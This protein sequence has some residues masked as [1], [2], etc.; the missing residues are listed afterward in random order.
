[1][2]QKRTFAFIFLFQVLTFKGYS[3]VD[4]Q[5]LQRNIHI[6]EKDTNK[7]F[8]SFYNLNFLKNNEYF[9][10]I[11][12]GY[13]LFGSN[14]N[15]RFSYV[16]NPYTRIEAGIFL[17]KDFGNPNFTIIAPTLTLKLQKNGYSFLFGNLESS[18]SHQLI[19]P[20]FNYERVINNP[21]ENGLQIKVDKQ[22]IWLDAWI[23]WEQQEY[24][25]SPFQEHIGASLSSLITLFKSDKN[26]K[27]QIP[28][29][30]IIYHNGGQIDADTSA[31]VSLGNVASGIILERSFNKTAF[32]RDIKGDYYWVGYKDLTS[33]NKQLFKMGNGNYIN[34]TIKSKYDVSLMLSY[35][36]SNDFIA[37]HGGFLYQSISSLYGKTDY[38]E[39]VR[40]LIFARL[41]YK[42][43]IFKG[44]FLDVRFEPYYDI[45]HK[46]LEYSYSVYTSFT[47]D[48]LV[49]NFK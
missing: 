13:T 40:K 29:Q 44:L 42:L 10:K 14:T 26:F 15:S 23:D 16:F 34:L 37:P 17:R 30:A 18:L 28:V 41:L 9:D 3:Q 48:F 36:E 1:M 25:N 46:M 19:E 32:I 35:W 33:Y 47:R 45:N 49:K 5:A 11:A 27:I 38:T 8:F 4:N 7:L 12:S 2:K 24:Q 21:L 20:L 31:L 6:L 43:E 22:K 39:N